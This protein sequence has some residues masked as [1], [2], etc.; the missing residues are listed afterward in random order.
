MVSTYGLGVVALLKTAEVVLTFAAT[1]TV[2]SFEPVDAAHNVS[3]DMQEMINAEKALL[4]HPDFIAAV[5][6]MDLPSNAKVVADGW[7]Y[8]SDTFTKGSRKIPFMCYL[9]FSDNPDTCHYAAPLPIVPVVSAEDYTLLSLDYCPIYGTGEKT[10][11][12]Y[13]GRFPWEAYMPNEYD[14][15]IRAAAGQATRS[16][17]KPYRVIQPEG[18]SVS[19]QCMSVLELTPQFILQ[20]RV[21][22]WQKWSLHIGFN[23]REGLVLSDVRYDG[24][25]TFYR[26]S[27]SDMTVPYGDP[28][29]PYHRKQAFDLGDVGAGLTANELALGCDCLGEILYLDYDHWDTKGDLVRL[30]GVVCIHEQDDGIGWKHTNFRTNKPSVTRSR[31]LIIQTIVSGDKR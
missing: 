14:A 19:C 24:R 22:E 27:V 3:P 1:T 26:L 13:E 30:K 20:G 12:D 7:I 21:L 10:L 28:R 17:L 8:G 25:K 6:K 11:L 2:D 4:S 31:V 15:S 5:A 16:D 9:S 23:H 18:T 29:S